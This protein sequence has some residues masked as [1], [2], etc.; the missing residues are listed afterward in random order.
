VILRPSWVEKSEH[1]GQSIFDFFR[2]FFFV[3]FFQED[4]LNFPGQ[5]LRFGVSGYLTK[6]PLL[7]SSLRRVSID[8]KMPV[9]ELRMD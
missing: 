7:V 8:T 3:I 5:R 9:V 4:W 2:D 6:R 1:S